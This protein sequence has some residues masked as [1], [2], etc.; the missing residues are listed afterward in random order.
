[1]VMS[2]SKEKLKYVFYTITHPMDGFYE[3]RHRGRGSVPL[4]VLLVFLFALCFSAN[5]QYAGF[6]VNYLNP[7]S[8]NSLMEIFS[9]FVLFFLFCVGNWSITCLMNGEGRLKDVVTVTGYAML[10]MILTFIPAIILSRFVAADEEAFYYLLMGLGIV[11]FALL[12]V[13]GIMT[14]HNYTVGK[15]VFTMIL[16]FAAILIIIFLIILMY[17][18]LGQVGSFMDSMY[19]ELMLRI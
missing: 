2:K 16:T 12:V 8:I 17:S 9:V 5:R 7:M 6:V 18:L 15:T 14:V 19:N 1:M 4:A 3:I 13:S 10:P 11:W